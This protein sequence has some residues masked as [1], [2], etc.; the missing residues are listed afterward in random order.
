M[1]I[2]HF[3]QP[4]MIIIINMGSFKNHGNIVTILLLHEFHEPR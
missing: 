4:N 3:R 2:I 1:E